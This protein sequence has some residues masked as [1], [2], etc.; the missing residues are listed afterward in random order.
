MRKISDGLSKTLLIVESAGRPFT[1]RVSQQVSN[2]LGP[3]FYA[4]G[5]GWSDSL[6]PFKLDS[7][8]ADGTKGAPASAGVAVNA[9]NEGE[10]YSFHSRGA[11][12][13]FGDTSTRFLEETVDLRVYCSMITRA[14]GESVAQP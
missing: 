2:P 3:M 6:G 9:T 4:Q 11:G 12:V 14:G 5:V 13:V 1:Y 10:T 7:I 8:K